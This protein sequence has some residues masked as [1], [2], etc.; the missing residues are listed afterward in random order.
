MYEALADKWHSRILSIIFALLL[1]GY[2]IVGVITSL[3]GSETS[4][5]A[6][7]FR[8]IIVGVSLLSI[9]I[10][11]LRGTFR[12]DWLIFGFLVLYLIRLIY[13]YGYLGSVDIE[14]ALPF[15]VSSVF[16]PVLGLAAAARRFDERSAALYCV[17]V[18]T[19][20]CLM[21]T[22]VIRETDLVSQ[23]VLA[24]T[25]GRV[26]LNALNPIALSYLG[27]FTAASALYRLTRLQSGVLIALCCL[28]IPLG[29]YVFFM[30][31]SR[32]P[33]LAMLVGVA[34]IGIARRRAGMILAFL[35]VVMFGVA[36]TMNLAN[37]ATER[38]SSTGFDASSE[39]RLAAMRLSVEEAIENPV[40]GYAYIE[41]VTGYY[42]H[43]LLI[44]S[45]L[46]LG[47]GGAAIMLLMQFNLGYN[48]LISVRRGRY[49][50]PFC[51]AAAL[52]NAW[53]SGAIWG[54]DLFF[55]SLFLLRTLNRMDAPTRLVGS[56]P[57]RNA[58][59]SNWSS[60][61]LPQ[62]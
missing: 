3:T 36:T 15:F 54:A 42:P 14:R 46:A 44:E 43:N 24:R 55:V 6:I 57:L 20:A 52:A 38:L 51:A 39:V 45:G 62:R 27:L 1:V 22:Y 40:F 17:I 10:G 19:I 48:A 30:G 58:N 21:V 34:L 7:G 41:P 11:I 59:M 9:C 5:Y 56:Q 47:L 31:G 32:G 28:A 37:V 8:I 60:A 50:I 12:I 23:E 49:F 18:G 61:T 25:A 16:M 33:V 53:L 29:L 4:T 35:I 2:P 26:E 13:D